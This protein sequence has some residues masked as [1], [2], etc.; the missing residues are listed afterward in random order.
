MF[1]IILRRFWSGWKQALL[2][3]QPETVVTWHRVGFKLY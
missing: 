1:W 3:V 2:I